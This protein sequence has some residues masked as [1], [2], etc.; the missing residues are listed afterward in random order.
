MRYDLDLV[1]LSFCEVGLPVRNA[2]QRV[3]IDL[4]PSVV[5]YFQNAERE[6]DCSIGF[7]D[8]PWHSHDNLMFVGSH[9]NYI[10]LGYLDLAAAL[11]NGRVLICERELRGQT[12]DRWLIHSGFND[13]FKH[14]AEGERIIARHAMTHPAC[15]SLLSGN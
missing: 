1:E 8:T 5:L 3:E 11:K 4:G 13:E 6:D 15:K 2:D 9:G 12:V 14:V 10:E 7:L